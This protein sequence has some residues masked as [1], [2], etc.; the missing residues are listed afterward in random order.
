MSY[1]FRSRLGSV[2]SIIS[3]HSREE[4]PVNR[5]GSIHPHDERSFSPGTTPV[6]QPA[7]SFFHSSYHSLN[8]SGEWIAY[9]HNG[10]RT[11]AYLVSTGHTD[12]VHQPAHTIRDQTAELA[13]Y[14]LSEA[15]NSY[16]SRFS[17]GILGTSHSND[18]DG[19][20]PHLSLPAPL[21]RLENT[22]SQHDFEPI[23]E[24]SEPAS[25]A[26]QLDKQASHASHLT[27]LLRASPSHPSQDDR[28]DENGH[29]NVERLHL[30]ERS[31]L[32][33][34][35]QQPAHYHNGYNSL[36]GHDQGSDTDIE[37]QNE[38]ISSN[39]PK[40]TVHRVLTWPKTG[41]LTLV[42]SVFPHGGGKLNK[43][44]LWETIVVKPVGY[45]PAVVL[46]LLLNVLDGLSYG[47]YIHSL[48]YKSTTNRNRHDIVP[49]WAGCLQWP[50]GGW[51]VYVLC[52]L[53]R[54]TVGLFV[55]WQC[56]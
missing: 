24:V 43:K 44:E 5:N 8:P 1:S 52:E 35:G 30:S 10:C 36:S 11:L 32:L 6:K 55:R 23:T 22:D 31:S 13:T 45:V 41:S 19:D 49:P 15:V 4:R 28:R 7:R 53:H 3:F 20:P 39:I 42:K 56:L 27:H 12:N 25:P 21:L 9:C 2:S 18:A 48:R 38:N 37:S 33:S 54:R 17:P 47:P 34:K 16:Q 51:P 40:L 46:G 26:P 50:W 14:A 29:Y